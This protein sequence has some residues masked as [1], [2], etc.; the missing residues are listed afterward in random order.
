MMTETA[1]L[2]LIEDYPQLKADLPGYD[3]DWCRAFREQ[4]FSQFSASGFPSPREEEWRYTNVSA[5]EKKRFHWAAAE[6]TID[7]AWVQSLFLD[8]CWTVVLIDGVFSSD[9]SRLSG[10][11]D[12][13][14]VASVAEI[15]QS[16]PDALK[17]Y[18]GQA[19]SDKEHNFIAFN[20]AWFRDG[21]FIRV[22]AGVNL[23]QSIQIVHVTTQTE[24]L[25][26]TRQIFVLQEGAAAEIIETYAGQDCAYLTTSVNEVFLADKAQLSA[27][28]VQQEAEQAWHFGGWYVKQSAQA[29]FTHHHFAFGGLLTRTDIHCDLETA[30]E[31]ELNGLFLGMK[32]QHQDSHTR[33]VHQK[34]DAI[35][36]EQYKGVLDQRARG[37]FQGRVIVAQDAQ[38][39][40]SQMNNQNLLL[41]EYAEIDTKPQLEI[42]ADDV[43]CAHGVTVGQLDENS[44][45]YCQSRG[46]DEESARNM[47]TF[48]F[49][50]QMVKKLERKDLHD[51]VLSLLLQRFPQQG[52]DS[53]WL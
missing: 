8:D 25:S 15:L 22:E 18:L 14:M 42:Y 36:R 5:I 29:Q 21:I 7:P 41:S 53:S 4:A 49:A 38:R 20:S 6:K 16:N 35:S 3:V 26:C 24:T 31:C 33:I 10:L 46:L 44:V 2:A 50:N 45:F 43:K 37:V 39:T 28:K 34:P 51:H 9:Y 48:A 27:S 40:D 19:V 52:V 17:G 11:P 1:S 12:G 32:R 30:A 13:V 47:L 23:E